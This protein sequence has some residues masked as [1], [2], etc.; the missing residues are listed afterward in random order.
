MQRQEMMNDC[1]IFDSTKPIKMSN[2]TNKQNN[3]DNNIKKRLWTIKEDR[4]LQQLVQIHGASNWTKISEMMTNRSGKQ[5][6]NRWNNCL[7]PDFKKGEW[8]KEEDSTILHSFHEIGKQ[9]AKVFLV[10]SYP[11]FFLS[12]FHIYD[13]IV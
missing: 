12:C 7:N 9:W 4:L 2:D 8:T 11:L 10:N 6:H 13:I 5:C 3:P 1:F